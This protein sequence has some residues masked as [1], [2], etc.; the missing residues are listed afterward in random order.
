MLPSLGIFSKAPM[1]M[2]KRKACA[3][4]T[5]T[6]NHWLK[7]PSSWTVDH[8]SRRSGLREQCSRRKRRLRPEVRSRVFW[9]H[10][11]LSAWLHDLKDSQDSARLL[12]A[13]LRQFRK[14]FA[15][16]VEPLLSSSIFISTLYKSFLRNEGGGGRG[17]G[18]W[19]EGSRSKSA[20]E[21]AKCGTRRSIRS[22]R[23]PVSSSLSSPYTYL[24]CLLDTDP[25]PRQLKISKSNKNIGSEIQRHR[26]SGVEY[27]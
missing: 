5:L 17:L 11:A 9:H 20:I 25:N 22:I 24:T 15:A 8:Q 6:H 23:S 10:G 4:A 13:N 2:M 7:S 26:T 21:S 27:R 12:F 3:A 19:R 1:A 14:A 18:R 16:L